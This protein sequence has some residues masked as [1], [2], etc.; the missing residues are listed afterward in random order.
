MPAPDFIT[1]RQAVGLLA[2]ATVPAVA[3]TRARA[4]EGKS[5]RPRILFFTKSSGYEHDVVN[6]NGN[7][8]SLAE[9]RLPPPKTAAS[10]MATCRLTAPSVS[11]RPGT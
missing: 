9:R 2:A 5:E 11:S 7:D 1:R 4:A 3:L 6:R 8:L 10:S